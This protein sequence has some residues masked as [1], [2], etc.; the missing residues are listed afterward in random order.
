MAD[1]QQ[2]GA[3]LANQPSP[4][5]QGQQMQAIL[6]AL[7]GQQQG[8]LPGGGFPQGGLPQAG[9]FPQGGGLPQFGG[10]QGFP[11]AGLQG[12][13]LPGGGFPG[14]G[15]PGGGGGMDLNAMIASLLQQPMGPGANLPTGFSRGF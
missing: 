6:A 9:G 1:N 14:G 12:Q 7:L 8:G 11:A 5:F 3:L 13:N 15:F 2:I 10:L 4:G